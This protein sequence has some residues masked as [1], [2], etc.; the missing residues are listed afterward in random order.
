MEEQ[1]GVWAQEFYLLPLQ[2]ILRGK[3]EFQLLA[4]E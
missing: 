3:L 2:T 1:L 4:M